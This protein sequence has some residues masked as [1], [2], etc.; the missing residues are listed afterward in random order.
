[1]GTLR[2]T[3]TLTRAELKKALYP[4]DIARMR[5]ISALGIRPAISGGSARRGSALELLTAVTL[6]LALVGL[7]VALVLGIFNY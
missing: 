1:M 4:G 6:G 7:G 3:H 5:E 2:N